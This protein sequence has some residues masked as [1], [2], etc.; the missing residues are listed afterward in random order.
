MILKNYFFR[1]GVA[2]QQPNIGVYWYFFMEMFEHFRTFFI[3]SYQ[4]NVTLL[5]FVP[6]SIKF[7]K[8]PVLL[9]TCFVTIIA[10][11]KSY[12]SI[13]DFGFTLAL[14][15]CWKH[16]YNCKFDQWQSEPLCDV[17]Y[18]CVGAFLSGTTFSVVEMFHYILFILMGP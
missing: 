11:F 2:D 16:M 15:P 12:P 10:I 1:L 4:I 18:S 14:L 7:R 6:L 3:Y 17:R 8:D 13:G 5:Y 9:A